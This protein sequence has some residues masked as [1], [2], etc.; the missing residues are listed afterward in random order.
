MFKLR[1]GLWLL[2]GAG[3]GRSPLAIPCAAGEVEVGGDCVLPLTCGPGT[4]Q[5]GSMCL[6]D[7]PAPTDAAS[8]IPIDAAVP[9]AG[10]PDL[11]DLAGPVDDPSNPQSSITYQVDP[12]HTGGL[13]NSGLRPPLVRRW[14]V[15]LASA[16]LSYPVIFGGLV[17]VAGCGT[18]GCKLYALSAATG[19]LQWGPID[20]SSGYAATL[21]YHAGHIFTAGQD[22][23][24]FDAVTGAATWTH[25]LGDE[26]FVGPPVVAGGSV[27]V[28]YGGWLYSLDEQTGSERWHAPN[29]GMPTSPDWT[30]TMVVLEYIEGMVSALSPADGHVLW[31]TP[32]NGSGGGGDVPVLYQGQVWAKDFWSKNV[33]LDAS[34]GKSLGQFSASTV[35][36]FENGLGFFLTTAKTL[37]GRE[38]TGLVKWSFAGDGNL[39]STPLAVGGVVYVGSSMGNLYALDEQTG[40]EL[41]VDNLGVAIA[42]ANDNYGLTPMAGLGASNDLLVVPAGATLTAYE[43][44]GEL[45]D[46]RTPLDSD[47]GGV[48]AGP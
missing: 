25:A 11:A 34:N 38:L 20:L 29:G 18:N 37:E 13:P 2:L 23:R 32:S 6:A 4:H 35:P 48:D 24:A 7:S 40:D 44:G 12:A 28:A 31:K 15:T 45:P 43:H 10:H 1:W 8:S 39:G 42:T 3:C 41:W 46:L 30:P 9:D 17:Y 16:S 26:I 14:S 36:A 33:I 47:M 22:T 21:A 27:Y 5:V 19:N